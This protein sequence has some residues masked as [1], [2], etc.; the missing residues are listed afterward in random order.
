MY[1]RLIGIGAKWDPIDKS[2]LRAIS[3]EISEVCP[4]QSLYMKPDLNVRV[5]ECAVLESKAKDGR[6]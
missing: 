1:N 2:K 4:P 3:K 5:A 6:N